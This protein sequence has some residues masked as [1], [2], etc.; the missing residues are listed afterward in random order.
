MKWIY[1]LGAVVLFASCSST[2]IKLVDYYYIYSP[3]DYYDTYY[4]KCKLSSNQDPIVDSV[5]VVYW[6]DSTIIVGS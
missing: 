4:L 3:D 2:G 5:Q 1:L 6:N